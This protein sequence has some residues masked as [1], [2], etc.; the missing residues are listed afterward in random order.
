[1][2]SFYK[3]RIIFLCVSAVITHW[4]FYDIVDDDDDQVSKKSV[5]HFTGA[6]FTFAV[7][8]D[9]V[10]V[11]CERRCLEGVYL[12]LPTYASSA[13]LAMCGAAH[14]TIQLSSRENDS[15]RHFVRQKQ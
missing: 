9:V 1:M 4:N 5:K 13:W 10:V 8:I 11:V 3:S 14:K 15:L 6:L 2:K 12:S 7:A